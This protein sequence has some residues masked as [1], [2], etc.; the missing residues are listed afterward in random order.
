MGGFGPNVGWMRPMVW[1]SC[2]DLSSVSSTTGDIEDYRAFPNSSISKRP[3]LDGNDKP[4]MLHAGI[5]VLRACIW[6]VNLDRN[7]Y[8]IES[9]PTWVFRFPLPDPAVSFA[10]SDFEGDIRQLR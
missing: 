6:V 3:T 10:G 9:L 7:Y 5:T 4:P 8:R 1:R 2:E